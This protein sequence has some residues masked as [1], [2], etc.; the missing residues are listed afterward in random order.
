MREVGPELSR[1]I[2]RILFFL[3]QH[4]TL[5]PGDA[6]RNQGPDHGCP[7][8]GNRFSAAIHTQLK[9]PVAGLDPAIHVFLG[10][11][12]LGGQGVDARI[13][14]GQGVLTVAF[15]LATLD[16]A[17][18]QS[19][20]RIALRPEKQRPPRALERQPGVAGAKHSSRPG[21]KPGLYLGLYARLPMPSGRQLGLPG[22]CHVDR[23][24]SH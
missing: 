11:G 5:T 4:V 15:W 23:T 10:F 16:A 19:L 9:I 14:S 7:V 6:E 24:S 2:H 8:E 18:S 3:D 20:N 1:V 13:K 12:D 17:L 21:P 22:W